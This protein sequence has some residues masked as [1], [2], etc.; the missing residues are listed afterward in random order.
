MGADALVECKAA[1]KFSVADNKYKYICDCDCLDS[2]VTFLEDA[3]TFVA[4]G[5]QVVTWSCDGEIINVDLV[6]K[7]CYK[8]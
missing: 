6:N 7:L 8:G 4:L 5:K 1:Y 3:V 2:P